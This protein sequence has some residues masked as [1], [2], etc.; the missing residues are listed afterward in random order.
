MT[1]APV[2]DAA[3]RDLIALH[4]RRG[5]LEQQREP[6]T[7]G[8]ERGRVASSERSSDPRRELAVE[9]HLALVDAKPDA[10]RTAVLVWRRRLEHDGSRAVAVA[11]RVVDRDAMVATHLARA[12]L[13]G[14]EFGDR[15]RPE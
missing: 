3:A 13:L 4:G 9:P 14:T 2:V 12:D 11:G 5:V 8:F 15:P 1:G 10:R 7:I 6:A